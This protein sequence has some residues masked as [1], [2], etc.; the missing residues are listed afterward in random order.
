MLETPGACEDLNFTV[1]LYDS[2]KKKHKSLK[3]I[4]KG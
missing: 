2:F 4:D 1:Q 3:L